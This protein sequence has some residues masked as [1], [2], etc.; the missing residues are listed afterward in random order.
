MSTAAP[1]S[2]ASSWT[3]TS[4]S[5]SRRW[6][7][8]PR[9]SAWRA[10]DPGLAAPPAAALR[11]GATAGR[12]GLRSLQTSVG[13]PGRRQTSEWRCLMVEDR[14]EVSLL[15]AFVDL[16]RFFLQSQRVTD[17]DLADTLDAFYECVSARIDKSG[18]RV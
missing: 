18:G 17:T 14:A 15:I 2:S 9:R 4:R 3:P 11:S 8:W 12:K 16:T 5:S 1:P 13:L 7:A 6:R 10:A